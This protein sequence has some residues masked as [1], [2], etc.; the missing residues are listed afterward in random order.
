VPFTSGQ[1]ARLRRIFPGG[2]C[3]WRKPGVGQVP[4]AATWIDYGRR[5]WGPPT[6]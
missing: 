2:V 1:V 6:R 4:L 3:D 5:P